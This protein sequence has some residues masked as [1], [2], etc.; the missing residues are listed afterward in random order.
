MFR[1]LG[2]KSFRPWLLLELN[3]PNR[4]AMAEAPRVWVICQ[5]R[6]HRTPAHVPGDQVLGSP[7]PRGF[8]VQIS[9]CI[10]LKALQAA[11]RKRGK[12][13][14][15]FRTCAPRAAP[16]T[17][18]LPSLHFSTHTQPRLTGGTQP[19]QVIA[20]PEQL[21][22]KWGRLG[23]APCLAP[24]IDKIWHSCLKKK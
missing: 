8:S 2:P 15:G 13:L 10:S 5:V 7:S 1:M 22:L 16:H 19:L 17:P 20:F 3:S 21:I 12:C 4:A 6:C 14:L 23:L 9:D 24:K 18:Q 11:L